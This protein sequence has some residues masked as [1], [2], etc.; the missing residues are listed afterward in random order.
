M[1]MALACI[2]YLDA[3]G[4]GGRGGGS[5]RGSLQRSPSMSRAAPAR[6]SSRA[7]SG[8]QSRNDVQNVLRT[9][10]A[11]RAAG[12]AFEN[13]GA[14]LANRHDLAQ[15]V[16]G[17][18]RKDRPNR[19]NWFDG[20]FW[21]NH[22]YH[23]S[24]YNHQTNGWQLATALGVAGWLGW[25]A[26]PVYYDYADTGDD[27]WG[28]ET[29]SLYAD[30]ALAMDSSAA[31]QSESEWMPLGVF[32]LSKSEGSP[33]APNI[34]LQ[35][36]LNKKGIISGTYYNATNDQ[37]YEVEGIVDQKTQKAAWKVADSENAPI[38]ETGIY[39]L[40]QP[41][42]PIRIHFNNGSIHQKMLVRLD[43]P[44]A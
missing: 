9:N 16:R 6:P 17:E 25:Q 3:R 42:A 26:D 19:G 23:P 30:T 15:N 43:E 33:I 4:G 29:S 24:Y 11:A 18:I 21:D 14:P 40:T 35:L 37:T 20:N 39:N 44:K 7:V 12:R 8:T 10:T 36:A 32:G 1:A 27:Y 38:F 28:S 41:E 22:H 5:S 34:Y 13:R 2:F 31:Q